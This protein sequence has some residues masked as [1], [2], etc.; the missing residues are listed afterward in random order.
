MNGDFAVNAGAALVGT[1]TPVMQCSVVT[2]IAAARSGVR[3]KNTHFM[4]SDPAKSAQLD[5]PS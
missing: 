2:A 1:T 3:A 5:V 4:L